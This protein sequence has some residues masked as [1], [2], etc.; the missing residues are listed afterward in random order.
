MFDV[1][2]SML[3]DIIEV[4]TYCN[5]AKNLQYI[6]EEDFSLIIAKIDKLFFKLLN[7]KKYLKK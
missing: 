7:L 3:L 6:S 5:I 2:H 1:R 4:K